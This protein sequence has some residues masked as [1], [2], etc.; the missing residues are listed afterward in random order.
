VVASAAVAVAAA[1]A[2][3]T[4]SDQGAFLAFASLE[5]STQMVLLCMVLL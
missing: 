1:A 3:A 5:A 2:A 4:S